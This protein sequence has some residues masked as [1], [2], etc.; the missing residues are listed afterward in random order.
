ME[1][2]FSRD[3]LSSLLDELALLFESPADQ[4]EF[5]A[6]LLEELLVDEVSD[7]PD[8]E[9]PPRVC[10]VGRT[11]AGKSSL[12]N[13]LARETIAEVGTVKSTTDDQ[14][15]HE[16]T[17]GD[18]NTL[19]EVVDFRGLFE[20]E[21]PD[22]AEP[23]D[24]IQAA[25][26]GLKRLNPDFVLHVTTA[27][28]VRGGRDST[29]TIGGLGESILG[30][31][32]P[33]L[34]CVNKVDS[35]LGPADDWPP[36]A[37]QGFNDRIEELL[38]LVEEIAASRRTSELR[39]GKIL[40][41]VLFS[42]PDIIGAVPMC[43]DSSAH[44]NRRGLVSLLTEHLYYNDRFRELRERRR[45]RIG[46]RC[47]RTQTAVIATV[48]HNLPNSVVTDENRYV[49]PILQRYLIAL[50]G[51][52]AGRELSGGSVE[53]Y[54]DT[55]NP[56]DTEFDNLIEYAENLIRGRGSLESAIPAIDALARSRMPR[57]SNS[58]I[59]KRVTEAQGK[60]TYMIGR[61]AE[62][63]FFNDTNVSPQSFASDAHAQLTGIYLDASGAHQVANNYFDS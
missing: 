18:D 8:D 39:E 50:I 30:G 3:T 51:A 21:P 1:T 63:Y 53:E 26:E 54:L 13:T 52:F 45:R 17:L 16:I 2:E 43:A 36:T 31:A 35:S 29:E 27:D 38:D 46:I 55:A 15:I 14:V 56:F 20:I 22:G 32:P 47:A 57:M 11:G 6:S 23:A 10:V 58:P 48:V 4:L 62:Q 61:S 34:I 42:S 59:D 40:R 9:A 37:N 41:G 44:W 7:I 19:W 49:V 33:R 25:V 24:T 28:Y 60:L 12:I 5:D